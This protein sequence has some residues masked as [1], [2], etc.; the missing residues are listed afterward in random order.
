ML[1]RNLSTGELDI[2]H[3]LIIALNVNKKM[4]VVQMDTNY[5]LVLYS[6]ELWDKSLV[7][8]EIFHS[9]LW[10]YANYL[11]YI[12]YCKRFEIVILTPSVM[13]LILLQSCN[14]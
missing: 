2:L 6:E 12:P 7:I 4:H 13:M 1:V 5:C 14:F 11:Q 3:I 10:F 8:N 9:L